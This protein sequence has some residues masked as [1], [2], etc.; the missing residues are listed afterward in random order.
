MPVPLFRFTDLQIK[1]YLMIAVAQCKFIRSKHS[2]TGFSTYNNN[3]KN[4]PLIKIDISVG[5]VKFVAS[6]SLTVFS[7]HDISHKSALFVDLIFTDIS[8]AKA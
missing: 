7:L 4:E 3:N 2:Q 5:H 8:K 1:V 6:L